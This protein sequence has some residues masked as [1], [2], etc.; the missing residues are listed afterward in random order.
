MATEDRLEKGLE[1]IF[2]HMKKIGLMTPAIEAQKDSIVQGLTEQLSGKLSPDDLKD[3]TVQMRLMGSIICKGLNPESKPGLLDNL[4]KYFTNALENNP[5]HKTN[6]FEK[7]M[8][9]TLG[10]FNTKPKELENKLTA[11]LDRRTKTK[12][13]LELALT[14]FKDLTL[15]RTGNKKELDEMG[16]KSS[17]SNSK[18]PLEDFLA[19][20]FSTDP[21]FT[22][23]LERTQQGPALGNQTGMAE[24]GAPDPVGTSYMTDIETYN[25]GKVGALE[26]SAKNF[27][28]ATDLLADITN[29]ITNQTELKY[30]MNDALEPKNDAAETSS[31]WP[32][33]PKFPGQL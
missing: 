2:D 30:A 18:D 8:M 25:P 26:A 17:S 27:T 22:G 5:K 13:L 33:K 31:N 19:I 23:G 1:V 10:L 4:G 21:R 24:I 28:T 9:F 16:L 29:G 14:S 6:E 7:V 20:M 15:K 12:S 11:K 3:R 32:P